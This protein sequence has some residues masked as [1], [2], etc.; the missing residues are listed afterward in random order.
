MKKPYARAAMLLF[1]AC[2]CACSNS[3]TPDP[4]APKPAAGV[5]PGGAAAPERQLRQQ[6]M[7][8]VFEAAYRPASDDALVN[9]PVPGQPKRMADYVVTMLDQH[10]LADGSTALVTN[11]AEVDAGGKASS[12]PQSPGVLSVFILKQ[13][14]GQWNVVTRHENVAAL[15]AGGRV[16]EVSWPELARDKPGLA[17]VS[18]TNIEGNIVSKLSLFDPSAANF[19]NMTE[20]LPIHAD[21]KNVCDPRTGDCWNVTAD[22]QMIPAQHASQYA[23]IE[24]HFTGTIV[25]AL[26]SAS[27]G[28]RVEAAVES[29]ARYVYDGDVYKLGDGQNLVKDML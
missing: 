17:I 5:G 28:P 9:L 1:C 22:W 26:A 13:G 6:M 8:A 20:L 4:A 23:E 29:S 24:L 27:T 16:G 15:G 14:D 19:H 2:L 3:E 25:R 18:S 21:N 12:R 10:L 11:G 7:A